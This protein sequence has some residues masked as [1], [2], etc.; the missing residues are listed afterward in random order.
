[1]QDDVA[2]KNFSRNRTKWDVRSGSMS[3]TQYP[4]ALLAGLE[5]GHSAT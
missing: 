5:F 3:A 4:R 1:M 2:G